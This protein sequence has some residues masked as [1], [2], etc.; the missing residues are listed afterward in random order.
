MSLYEFTDEQI[1][2]MR[3][4]RPIMADLMAI[5]KFPKT[6]VIKRAKHEM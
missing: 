5:K 1:E 2:E 6:V 3:A 4:I